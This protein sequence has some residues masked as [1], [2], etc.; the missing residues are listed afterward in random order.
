MDGAGLA[1]DITMHPSLGTIGRRLHEAR[2]AAKLSL[3]GLSKLS[4][5]SRQAI[6]YWEHGTHP[7]VLTHLLSVCEALGIHASN[8]LDNGPGTET[9]DK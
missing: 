8:L 5:V 9:P 1:T 2:I 3:Q 7:P 4:G 6:A